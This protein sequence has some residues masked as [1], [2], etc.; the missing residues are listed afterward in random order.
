MFW[1]ITKIFALGLILAGIYIQPVRADAVDNFTIIDYKVDIKLSNDSESRSKIDVIETITAKFPDYDQNHGL[2]KIFVKD[3]KRHSTN[4]QLMSVT[5]GSGKPL[6]YHWEGDA[7][8]IGDPDIYVHGLQTY[9]ISYSQSDVT[10]FFE[11]TGKAEFYWDL[12]GL[13][14]RVPIENAV[15]NL[16]ISPDI[17]KAVQ[18]ELFCYAGGEGKIDIPCKVVNI[19][20]DPPRYQVTASNL[21]P[22]QGMSVAIGF[23]KGTFAESKYSPFERIMQIKD[24]LLP[25]A[26]GAVFVSTIASIVIMVGSSFTGRRRLGTIVPEYLPPKDVSLAV[27]GSILSFVYANRVGSA[28]M[29]DFAVRKYIKLYETK[30]KSFFSP[31]SY[32][33]EIIKDV[34]GLSEEEREVFSDMFAGLPN[35][36]DRLSLDSLYADT[37]YRLRVADNL[38]KLTKLIQDKYGLREPNLMLRKVLIGFGIMVVVSSIVI[39]NLLIASISVFIFIVAF[40]IQKPTAKGIELQR[41]LAGLKM[42]IKIAEEDRLRYLQSPEGAEKVSE[43]AGKDISNPIKRVVLYEKVLPYAILFGQEKQWSKQLGGLY[44]QTG[45]VPDWYS[46]SSGAFTASMFSSSIGSITSSSALSASSSTGGSSGGGSSGGG[47]GGG[48]GGGW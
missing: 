33:I 41:Y 15:V 18:T 35:V 17:K 13:D 45:N 37:G 38:K 1:G 32:D 44:E 14:W 22:R 48:G 2:E 47:G 28:Q 29:V 12:I 46:S 3:Y 25:W 27:A 30:A 10:R 16:E 6:S 9:K 43:I 36:G 31:A 11:N 4:L 26:I 7:L 39:L 24:T 34:N 21:Q 5:D 40:T 20:S 42:Y 23:S 8:R 19:S